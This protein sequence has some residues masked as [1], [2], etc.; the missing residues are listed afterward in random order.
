MTNNKKRES[1]EDSQNEPA[2]QFL[3]SQQYN[4][5]YEQIK[6]S[7]PFNDFRPA[8]PYYKPMKFDASYYSKS[9]WNDNKPTEPVKPKKEYTKYTQVS[10]QQT[11]DGIAQ[12]TTQ[13]LNE[14]WL[15]KEEIPE[16]LAGKWQWIPNEKPEIEPKQTSNSPFSFPESPIHEKHPYTFD[17]GESPFNIPTTTTLLEPQFPDVEDKGHKEIIR[18]RGLSPWSKILKLLTAVIPI[19][20]LLSALTPRVIYV[21]PNMTQ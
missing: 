8:N 18:P 6:K 2:K 21:N 20:L 11:Y 4:F 15:S 9:P 7:I 12:Q 13:N 16:K 10:Q 1:D 19:G 3:P 14:N 17:T 5:N